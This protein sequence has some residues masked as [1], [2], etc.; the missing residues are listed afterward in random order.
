M[1]EGRENRRTH[2]RA[3]SRL[4]LIPSVTPALNPSWLSNQNVILPL[5]CEGAVED[6]ILLGSSTLL[7][8]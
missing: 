2:Q 5:H 7:E 3:Y 8:E 4:S 6:P 1:G